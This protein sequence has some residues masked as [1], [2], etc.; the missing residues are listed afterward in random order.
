MTKGEHPKRSVLVTGAG[1]YIGRLLVETLSARRE[2]L[3]SVVAA[4]LF[5]PPPQQ[6]LPGVE[7]VVADVRSPYLETVMRRCEPEVVVHLAAIVTP[8]KRSNRKLEHSVDVLGTENV[9]RSCLAAGVEQFITTSSGAAYGYW[10]DNSEWLD[11]EDPIRG[12]ETFAYSHHKRLVEEMLARWRREHPELE[13]LIFRPGTVLGSTTRNQ[14]TALF[15][16]PWVLG[17]EGSASPFVLIWDQDVVE[18]I[19]KGIHERPAGIYNLAG[20]GVLTLRQI[21]SR[22]GKPYVELPVD[23]ITSALGIMK[24][25]GLTQYGPEQIDFL[26]YRPV[27]SNRRLKDELGYIPAKTTAEVFEHYIEAKAAS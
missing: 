21:A 22:L 3:S 17:L 16:K 26:R 20:D 15:E 25:I 5:I 13:Q 2:E 6:R 10:P 14:I 12:N 4:D 11:E 23:L 18:A 24:R 8:G 7:Y 9:L 19:I 1:G 27:L